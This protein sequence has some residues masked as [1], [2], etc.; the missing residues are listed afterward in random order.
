MLINNGLQI[1]KNCP[2]CNKV[3]KLN[4][5]S[6]KYRCNGARN[7][8]RCNYNAPINLFVDRNGNKLNVQSALKIVFE[9]ARVTPAVNVAYD[10]DVHETTV[11]RLYKSCNVAAKEIIQDLGIETIGGEGVVVAVYEALFG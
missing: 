11:Q 6:L 8:V 10:Y 7:Y 2:K 1:R 4:L 5:A 3:V 9:W